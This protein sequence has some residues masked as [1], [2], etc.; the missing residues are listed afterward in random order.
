MPRLLKVADVAEQLQCSPGR[1]RAMANRGDLSHRRDGRFLRFT[2]EDV[3]RYIESTLVP[4][5]DYRRSKPR[6]KSA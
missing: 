5:T 6:R 4:G 3:D 2:Q 1:I